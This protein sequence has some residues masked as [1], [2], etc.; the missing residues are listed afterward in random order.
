MGFNSVFKG[1]SKWKFDTAVKKAKNLLNCLSKK[2]GNLSLNILGI[3]LTKF[4]QKCNCINI[5]LIFAWIFIYTR[6][7]TAIRFIKT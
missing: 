6:I 7:I 1:L 2:F 5:I 3:N 4:I